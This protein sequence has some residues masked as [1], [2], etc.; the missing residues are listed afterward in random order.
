MLST[1]IQEEGASGNPGSAETA[2]MTLWWS[3]LKVTLLLQSPCLA[4]SPLAGWFRNKHKEVSLKQITVRC[5][6]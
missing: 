4:L 1:L 2:A 5:S 6:F 3:W